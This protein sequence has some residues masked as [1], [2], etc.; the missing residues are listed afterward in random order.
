MNSRLVLIVA[1]EASADLHGSHLVTALKRLDPGLTF[2]GIGGLRLQEA[3]VR[4]LFNSSD[5]AVVGLTEVVSRLATVTRAYLTLKTLLRK[6]RPVLLILMDY[7]DF[8]LRLACA[9]KQFRI[10]VLYYISPQVWAWRK[11]RVETIRRCVDRMAVIL[12]FEKEFYRERGLHVEHVGHPLLEEI[13]TDLDGEKVRTELGLHQASPVLALLPGSRKE[14]VTNLLPV[15][16]K[17]AE[18]I[19]SRHARL[20]CL[21]PR[22]STIPPELIDGL[23]E[24]TSLDVQVIQGDVYRVLKAC[25]LALVAS[26]TATLEAAILETPMVIVYRVSSF[27]YWIGRMVISVP[28][29]GLVNLVAGEEVVPE[30]IQDD[31]TPER[32]AREAMDILDHDDRLRE[33]A[34]KLR[35]LRETL[36][37]GSASGRTA[38]IALDMM[39]ASTTGGETQ[40]R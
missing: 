10:P 25:D 22:A 17:A 19:R 37:Q 4:I 38:R 3:G 33:M 9:A 36:G 5:M 16:I 8:N 40:K 24:E 20:K 1:G 7:P 32:L 11:G 39:E 30:L 18:R 2:W 35:A 27:S 23:L 6:N 29:I 28:F 14:E 31:V 26:G 12:P 15:M 13:P 21:L 34:R